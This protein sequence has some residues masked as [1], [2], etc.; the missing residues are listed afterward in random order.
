[1]VQILYPVQVSAL[2]ILQILYKDTLISIYFIIRKEIIIKSHKSLGKQLIK[3]I[4]Q[5]S[6]GTSRI[7]AQEFQDSSFLFPLML[8]T[9]CRT[10]LVGPK[11]DPTFVVKSEESWSLG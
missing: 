4:F 6:K 8:V 9:T 3:F 11:K 5:I 1:M 2:I 10:S 7:A